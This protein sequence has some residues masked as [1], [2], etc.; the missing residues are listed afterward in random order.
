MKANELMI[1]D[2][3]RFKKSKEVI[4]IFEIDGYRDVVNNE[5][6][7]YC[8][9]TNINIDEIEPISLTPEIL[10][11][12]NFRLHPQCGYEYMQKTADSFDFRFCVGGLF[13]EKFKVNMNGRLIVLNYVHELQH[14]LKSCELK[15]LA[16]N[17]NI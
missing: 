16:D 17:F 1:G 10:E 3:V 12:N 2:I 4:R 15:D 9:E 14:V 5:P 6:D 13:Q 11:K 8:S 7:G